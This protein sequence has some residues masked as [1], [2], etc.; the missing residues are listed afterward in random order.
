MVGIWQFE[1]IHVSAFDYLERISQ[2][3]NKFIDTWGKNSGIKDFIS[4]YYDIQRQIVKVT[5]LALSFDLNR[6]FERI[7]DCYR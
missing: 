5:I 4:T 6:L 1:P 2:I 3:E 7:A